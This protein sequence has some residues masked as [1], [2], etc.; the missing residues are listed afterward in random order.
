MRQIRIIT[1]ALAITA[2]LGS[3]SSGGDKTTEKVHNDPAQTV[4]AF[5]LGREDANALLDQCDTPQQLRLRLLDVRARITNIRTRV[6][7]EAADD[8]VTG[9]RLALEERGDTLASTL[10]N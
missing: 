1:I 10:F 9:F 2:M 5:Q 8:Y 4:R 7:P 6:S 3:C